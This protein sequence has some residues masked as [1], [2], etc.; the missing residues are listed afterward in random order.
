MDIIQLDNLTT[1]EAIADAF[2]RAVLAYDLNKVELLDSACTPDMTFII[3][4]YRVEGLEEIKRNNFAS[5]SLMDTG[6]L[7][8][9]F[10]IKLDDDGRRARVGAVGMHN[11]FR[12]GKGSEQGA[13]NYLVGAV[14][15]AVV[16]K[17]DDGLWKIKQWKLIPLY[18]QGNPAVMAP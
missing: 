1:N 4:G 6:H 2:Y 12:Q 17:Q 8:G 7:L 5:V 18:R 3:D 13:D 16:V 11:H 14:Y 9:N 10:R 15:D